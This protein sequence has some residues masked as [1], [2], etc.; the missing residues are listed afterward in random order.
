EREL[1][2]AVQESPANPKARLALGQLYASSERWP[3]AFE[4]F[5]AILK[6]DPNNWDALYQVGRT[7]AVSGQ[8]LDRAE[9]CLKRYLGH[10]PT[11]Q[12][13]PL[14][15]AHFRL[16][17]VYEKKGDKAKARAEY[18]EAVRLDPHLE[19]AKKALEKVK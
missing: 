10:A 17:M 4:A 6:A 15:N 13:A 16:G 9:E 14:A 3:D 8:R 18:Q 7:G 5:E 2:A 12:E 19:D 1:K 11:P